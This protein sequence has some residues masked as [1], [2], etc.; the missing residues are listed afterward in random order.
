MGAICSPGR[1]L[2]VA[3]AGAATIGA[4]VVLG[5]ALGHAGMLAVGLGWAGLVGTTVVAVMRTE[6]VETEQELEPDVEPYP[7][8]HAME[9]PWPPPRAEGWSSV[10]RFGWGESPPRLRVVA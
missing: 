7:V 2:L 6:S 10:Q 5:N 9:G 3:G 8:E 4:G 1:H